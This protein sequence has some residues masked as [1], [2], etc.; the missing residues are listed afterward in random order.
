VLNS[1]LGVMPVR[2]VD[3]HELPVPA[4]EEARDLREELFLR[5]TS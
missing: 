4:A 1:L 5:G 3:D 2:S